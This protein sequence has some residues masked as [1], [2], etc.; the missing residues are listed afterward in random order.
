MLARMWRKRDTPPL[1]VELQA[2]T[3]TGNQSGG[4][5]YEYLIDE[6]GVDLVVNP[7]Y[8]IKNNLHSMR[9]VSKHLSNAYIIPCD[10][11]CQYNPF[12]WHELYSW[13][14]VSDL[15]D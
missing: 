7:E 13:Y 14:M 5:K 12:H 4:I 1:L 6:Y 10:I 9:L 11:W 8:A 15:V 2:F 3:I